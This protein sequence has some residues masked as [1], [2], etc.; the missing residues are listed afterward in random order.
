MEMRSELKIADQQGKRK[1][2]EL[3]RNEIKMLIFESDEE[4]GSAAASIEGVKPANS[5][6]FKFY[7]TFS[8][9]HRRHGRNAHDNLTAVL[10]NLTADEWIYYTHWIAKIYFTT[11]YL[12]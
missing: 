9:H 7:A 10:I 11:F 2:W 4:G 12:T 3:L 1:S 8:Y 6:P 5:L